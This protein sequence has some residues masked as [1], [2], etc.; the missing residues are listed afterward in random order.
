MILVDKREDTPK[1]KKFLSLFPK[2]TAVMKHLT[3]GDFAFE[4]IGPDNVPIMVG[5]ERKTINDLINSI[6]SRRLVTHQLPGL[7]DHYDRCYLLVEGKLMAQPGTGN[8]IRPDFSKWN[9]GG[10]KG[11]KGSSRRF[12]NIKVAGRV[13]K[14]GDIINFLASVEEFW[15]VRILRTDNREDTAITVSSLAGWWGKQYTS[16]STHTDFDPHQRLLQV[17]AVR[18]NQTM[19]FVASMKGVGPSMALEMARAF[20]NFG[21]IVNADVKEI[22]GVKKWGKSTAGRLMDAVWESENSYY[23][24]KK[25]DKNE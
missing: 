14:K 22:A 19:R 1:Q 15:G 7:T 8:L 2:G 25:G 10:G 17:S 3:F 12:V 16:H 4:G 23:I 20:P 18:P 11:N 6:Q 24:K 21:E 13:V 9:R 5:I